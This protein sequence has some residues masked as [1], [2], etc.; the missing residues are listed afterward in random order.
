[1]SG[2]SFTFFELEASMYTLIS[3]ISNMNYEQEKATLPNSVSCCSI[4]PV[5]A[6]AWEF[7][8]Q[9][10]EVRTIV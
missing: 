10:K 3:H 6:I 9:C 8:S 5:D 7:S 1:M 4:V 2:H